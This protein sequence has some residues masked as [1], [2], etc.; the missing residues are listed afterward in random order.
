M[1]NFTNISSMENIY[2]IN[3]LIVDWLKIQAIKLH[4]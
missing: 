1:E 4:S 2:I 3:I